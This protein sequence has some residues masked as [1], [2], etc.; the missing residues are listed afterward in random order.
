MSNIGLRGL[1]QSAITDAMNEEYHHSRGQRRPRT[2]RHH[3]QRHRQH[4]D[5]Q[6]MWHARQDLCNAHQNA[7]H[8]RGHL[9][10]NGG[11]DGVDDFSGAAFPGIPGQVKRGAT[12][13]DGK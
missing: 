1:S 5:Q 2:E 9:P 8:D 6:R 3:R 10:V 7:I 13:A 4:R 11:G 12:N